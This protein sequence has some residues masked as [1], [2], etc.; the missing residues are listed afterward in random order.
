MWILVW[1]SY[2]SWFPLHVW[3]HCLNQAMNLTLCVY[4]TCGETKNSHPAVLKP[5]YLI[6]CLVSSARLPLCVYLYVPTK[7]AKYINLVCHYQFWTWKWPNFL[8][9]SFITSIQIRCSYNPSALVKVLSSLLLPE[10]SK[11]LVD[12]DATVNWEWNLPLKL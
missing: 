5:V 4:C 1:V 8:Y 2:I 9:I 3:H 7:L 12:F 11:F 6:E 10:F